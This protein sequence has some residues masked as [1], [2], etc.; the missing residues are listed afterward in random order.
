MRK[1]DPISVLI[2]LLF[3]FVNAHA[4]ENT[5]I[6][7]N[8]VNNK[9]MYLSGQLSTN[10]WGTDIRYILNKTFTLKA[11]VE[12]LNLTSSMDFSEN[13][14]DYVL[15][16]DYR[17][18]GVFVMADINY[19]RNLYITI[20]AAQNSLNPKIK[21]V[22][23]EDVPFGDI[24]IP[25]E[26]IGDFTFTLSP[27]MKISPYAGLGFRGFMGAKQRIVCFFETG[28]Y[29]LG[30]PNVEI[31]ATGLLAPT[32]DPVMG[33]NEVFEKQFSQYQFYP[34]VKLNLAIKLF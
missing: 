31:E 17:T 29:Y 5:P 26:M 23:A 6:E 19:T 34:V 11:G 13:G 32:A 9:G 33:Q 7:K 1:A 21:G 24:V 16:L 8:D 14:I 25:A 12:R 4:Q 28:F 10:G 18:G 3:F 30:P 27:S 15:D 20:G 22:A 2:F